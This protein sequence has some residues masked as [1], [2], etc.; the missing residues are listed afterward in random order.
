MLMVTPLP[1]VEPVARSTVIEVALA[2]AVTQYQP[3][4]VP[5]PESQMAFPLRALEKFAV[6]EVTVLV[7]AVTASVFEIFTVADWQLV[8]LVAF[9]LS[10]TDMSVPAPAMPRSNP[11]PLVS[12]PALRNS[13]TA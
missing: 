2:T 8:Q 12:E 6:A 13:Q 9:L 5:E 7:L 11:A 4:V 1:P 10:N 3:V